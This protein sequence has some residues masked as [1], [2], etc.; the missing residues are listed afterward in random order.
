LIQFQKAI[1]KEKQMELYPNLL[2]VSNEP[3]L[4]NLIANERD[5]GLNSDGLQ[6]YSLAKNN[7]MTIADEDVRYDIYIIVSNRFILALTTVA[8]CTVYIIIRISDVE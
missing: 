3:S 6:S 2:Q 5:S 4:A 7:I 1:F 8:S